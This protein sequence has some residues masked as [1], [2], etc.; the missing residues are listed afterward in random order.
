MNDVLMELLDKR[1]RRANQDLLNQPVPI[2]EDDDIMNEINL[3]QA[4]MSKDNPF[5]MFSEISKEWV[6]N[7]TMQDT[8][9]NSLKLLEKYFGRE[10]QD[11]ESHRKK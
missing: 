5:Y 2:S 8:L 10:I 7:R 4:E 9:R 6:R 3:E 1:I 11:R